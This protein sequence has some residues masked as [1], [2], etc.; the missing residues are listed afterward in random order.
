[1]ILAG[2]IGAT[3]TRLGTFTS[4]GSLPVA[5]ATFV[6]AE[7]ERP[8]ELIDAFPSKVG[9]RPERAS[10]GVAGVVVGRRVP[11]INLPCDID[12]AQLEREFGLREAILVNDVEANARG[13]LFLSIYGARA[14]DVALAYGAT[15]GVYL[16]GGIAPK[17]LPRLREGGFVRAFLAKGR[18]ESF[19]RPIPVRVVLNADAA[20][21]GAAL[22]AQDAA[23]LQLRAA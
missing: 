21:I 20:L 3:K 16:G 9:I 11:Q 14:G 10:F 4:R 12:A 6:T 13:D 7:F 15:G 2:D 18:L 8:G 23:D 1:M 19:V 22:Y 5:T 17:L